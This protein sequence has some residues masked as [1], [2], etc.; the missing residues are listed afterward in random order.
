MEKLKFV[1]VDPKLHKKLKQRALDKDSTMKNELDK[2]LE[3][4]L[5]SGENN[6]G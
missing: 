6:N 5:K 1:K 3:N 4:E 2:I